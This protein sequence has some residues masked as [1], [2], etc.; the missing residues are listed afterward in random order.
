MNTEMWT[1]IGTGVA[2]V[3]F[4]I[5]TGIGVASFVYTI[6]RNFKNDINL[7]FEKIDQR[8][9]KIDQRLDKMENKFNNDLVEIRR[10]LNRL[11]GALLYREI[12]KLERDDEHKNV[13]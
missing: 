13:S 5:G 6:I 2:I 11:E 4:I 7:R 9:E 3:S 10:S 8:F 1:I 12:L